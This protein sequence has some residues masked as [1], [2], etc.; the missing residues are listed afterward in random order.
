MFLVTKW[1][2]SELHRVRQESIAGQTETSGSP[3]LWPMRNSKTEH[4]ISQLANG[5][6][7]LTVLPGKPPVA[8]IKTLIGRIKLIFGFLPALETLILHKCK[9]VHSS[10]SEIVSVVHSGKLNT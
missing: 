5:A 7:L 3:H 1:Q 6:I 9:A 2:V 4:T 10:F 8:S